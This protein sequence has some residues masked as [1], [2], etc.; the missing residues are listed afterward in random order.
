[1]SRGG[2]EAADWV[3]AAWRHGARFDAWT[4]LFCEEAWREAARELGIDPA[5]IA[6][7]QWDTSR[8]MPWSHISTG[9][10]TRY[11]ALER[12]RASQEITTP[13]CTF[14]KCTGCGACQA[15]DCDNMLAGVRSLPSAPAAASGDAAVDVTPAQAALAVEMPAE[16]AAGGEDDGVP[17][18]AVAATA[19]PAAAKASGNDSFAKA[20]SDECSLSASEGGAR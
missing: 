15:L 19:S 4:E 7:A 20:A 3:E 8:V 9:V 14:E 6:Q 16:A 5:A 10:S 13:D 17:A 11:L 2:R 12:K 18:S 1:M